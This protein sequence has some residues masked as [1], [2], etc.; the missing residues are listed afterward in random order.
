MLDRNNEEHFEQQPTK[1]ETLDTSTSVRDTRPSSSSSS[2]LSLPLTQ[3]KNSD[4]APFNN[5]IMAT[6]PSTSEVPSSQLK[7]ELVPTE[8]DNDKVNQDRSLNELLKVLAVEELTALSNDMLSKDDAEEP[9]ANDI[10]QQ[11]IDKWKQELEMEKNKVKEMENKIL[12]SIR[13]EEKM[14]LEHG[15]QMQELRKQVLDQRAMVCYIMVD[16]M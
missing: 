3:I 2:N 13:K 10:L 11:E 4:S 7:D 9:I 14:Q 15:R 12:E 6:V 16:L 8:V 5:V 1:P